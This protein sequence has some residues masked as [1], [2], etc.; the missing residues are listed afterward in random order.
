MEVVGENMLLVGVVIFPRWEN[1]GSDYQGFFFPPVLGQQHIESER[2][3]EW[4]KR[5]ENW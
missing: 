4:T 3:C 2:M 5:S 1:W